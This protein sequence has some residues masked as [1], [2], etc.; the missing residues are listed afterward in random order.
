MLYLAVNSARNEIKGFNSY[1]V[2]GT[3]CLSCMP[4]VSPRDQDCIC[5][6]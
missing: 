4:F 5:K 2:D 6:S 1:A 3:E